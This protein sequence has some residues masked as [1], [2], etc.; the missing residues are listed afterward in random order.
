MHFN[1]MAAGRRTRMTAASL[2]AFVALLIAWSPVLAAVSWGA[3]HRAS[4][5]R[6]GH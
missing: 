4:T 1:P 6:G 2:T 3:H 5:R